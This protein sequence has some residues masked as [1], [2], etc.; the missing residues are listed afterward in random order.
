[1]LI[2]IDSLGARWT[3][4]EH[5]YQPNELHVD[6]QGLSLSGRTIVKGRA[7]RRDGRA[8]LEG[9][10]AA[11]V[12]TECDRCLTPL[13]FPIEATFTVGY[14]P[15]EEFDDEAHAEVGE[16]EA[17]IAA[18]EGEAINV[19]DLVREQLLLALPARRLCREECKGLCPV[20]GV[21]RNVETCACEEKE[22][23]PRWAALKSLSDRTK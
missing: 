21:N 7:A 18:L 20:C 2:E 3:P 12:R 5:E 22:I 8:K 10:L 19:D 1:M 16:D 13:E 15:E 11:T 9:T 23:D 17:S 6:E 4:F 14:V